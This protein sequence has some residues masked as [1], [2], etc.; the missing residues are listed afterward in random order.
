MK[1]F[2]SYSHKDEEWKNRLVTHL[3]V[4]EKQGFLDVW[5]DR[6]IPAGED[7]LPAIE[8][9]IN[10]ADAAIILISANFLNSDFILSKEIPALLQRR[11]EENMKLLPLIARPSA[12]TEIDWLSKIQARP[13]D[14]IA[15][16]SCSES[17]IDEYLAE[18]SIEVN[19]ILK[20]IKNESQHSESRKKEHHEDAVG[21][22]ISQKKRKEREQ[23]NKTNGVNI[24]VNGDR[25]VGIVGD[26][27]GA[28]IITGDNNVTDIGHQ[29]K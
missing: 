22:T 6:R 17:R 1:V 5:N 8:K 14:G 21:K 12:W 16:S 7:W 11:A 4:L 24:N 2:I 28:T 20:S 29:S 25:G 18:F 15:L 9:A 19:S 23:A 26:V 10:E 3:G 27:K 13:K